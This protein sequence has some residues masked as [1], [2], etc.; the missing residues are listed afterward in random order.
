MD[1]LTNLFDEIFEE[2][3]TVSGNNDSMNEIKS[4]CLDCGQINGEHTIYCEKLI[5]PID[6]KIYFMFL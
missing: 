4:I 6:N 1:D 2:D 3:L 5:N